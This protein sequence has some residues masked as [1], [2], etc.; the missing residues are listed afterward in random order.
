MQLTNGYVNAKKKNLFKL[1]KFACAKN[2][3][4]YINI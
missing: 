2:I 1:N 3:Y 4:I